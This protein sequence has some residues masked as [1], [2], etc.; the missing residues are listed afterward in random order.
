MNSGSNYNSQRDLQAITDRIS[1]QAAGCRGDTLALLQLLRSLEDLHREIR[2]GLFQESLPDNRQDLYS[3]VKD[4]EAQGGWPYINRMKLREILV[5]MTGSSPSE[6]D[7][8]PP[9]SQG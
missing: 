2:E 3:L 6:P 9:L 1:A 4:I 8:T 5:H 7:G